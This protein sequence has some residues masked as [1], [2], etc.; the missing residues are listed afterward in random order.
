MGW[1]PTVPVNGEREREREVGTRARLARKGR[2]SERET[3]TCEA[4]LRAY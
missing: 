2:A 3:E 1:T 4:S